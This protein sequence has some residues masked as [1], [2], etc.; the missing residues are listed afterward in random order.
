MIE[1]SLETLRVVALSKIILAVTFFFAY[2][3]IWKKKS[4]IFWVILSAIS[5]SSFYFIFASPMQNMFGGG[6]GDEIFIVS[7]L[8]QVLK[9]NFFADFYYA[10]LP[11]FYPPLFF[12]L[13]G[14]VSR[15]IGIEN[16]IAAYKIGVLGVLMLWF[17]GYYFW[18]KL[19]WKYIAPKG[20]KSIASQ[21][22]FWY[23]VPLVSFFLMGFDHI[24]S[25][26]YETFSALGIVLFLGLFSLSIKKTKWG[27]KEYSFFGI[28]GALLFLLYYFWWFMAIPTLFILAFMG[29]HRKKNI[30]RVFALGAIM[31]AL[32]SVYLVPLFF[33]YL[34]GIENWQAIYFVP[35]DFNSFLPFAQI[36]KSLVLILPGIFALIYFYKK[37][38]IRSGIFLLFFCYLYQYISIGIFLFGGKPL[39]AMKPF[40]FLSSVVFA[41]GAVYLL[42]SLHKKYIQA[43]SEEKKKMF[44]FAALIFSLLFWPMTGFIDDVGVRENIEKSI[45]SHPAKELALKIEGSIP[46][47]KERIWLSTGYP[48][49]NAYIPLHYYIAHNPHFSHPVSKYSKRMES[50]EVSSKEEWKEFI[51]T[52]KIN[53]FLLYSSPDE[54]N[55]IFYFWKDNYPNGGVEKQVIISKEYFDNLGLEKV[56]EYAD[57]E[58]F[59]LDSV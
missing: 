36:S 50:F 35:G 43:F 12:W 19:Y 14:G 29:E 1:L 5:L 34:G 32:S 16:A 56:F 59:V 9:G 23:F 15:F 30:I 42:F 54:E 45:A 28:S 21:K 53:A 6:V 47:Y 49:I 25:K 10:G 55:Y 18:Q 24:I 57:W 58:V 39:Q 4:P 17:L 40:L 31:F 51:K 38:F 7:F 26:P 8:S 22:W 44:F 2:F 33:S 48:M 37:P 27:I 41:V 20:E 3:F 52:N 11:A 13:T 46:D